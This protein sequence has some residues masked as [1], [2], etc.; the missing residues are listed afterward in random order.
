RYA[1]AA[2]TPASHL[3]RIYAEQGRYRESSDALQLIPDGIYKPGL[4]DAAALA[5]RNAP[6]EDRGASPSFANLSF[7]HNFIGAPE[8]VLDFREGT[9]KIGK[10]SPV[11]YYWSPSFAGVRKTAR[12]KVL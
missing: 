1:P 9:H 2:G 7:V 10:W 6:Q 8:R 12:W 3:A 11:Y 4:V 5:M